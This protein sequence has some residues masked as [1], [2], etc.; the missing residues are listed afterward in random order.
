[1]C[2]ISISK[3]GAARQVFQIFSVYYTKKERGNLDSGAAAATTPD[4]DFWYKVDR[5]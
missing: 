1:M 3:W 5:K 4:C 2:I